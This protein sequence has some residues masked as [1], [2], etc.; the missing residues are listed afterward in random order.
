MSTFIELL[1]NGWQWLGD[2]SSQIQ[3]ASGAVFGLA[4]VVIA[5]AAYLISVKEN[6]GWEPIAVLL[7][8]SLG[9]EGDGQTFMTA[10]F[11]V[12]NR[13]RYPIVVYDVVLTYR[14]A[15]FEKIQD[16]DDPTSE[17]W[18]VRS[19][20]SLGRV[21][22]ELI[23]PGKSKVFNMH[24]IVHGCTMM[25][26][27]AIAISYFD[28]IAAK[29]KTVNGGGGRLSKLRYDYGVWRGSL[30]WL[31]PELRRERRYRR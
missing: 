20:R 18:S 25:E 16:G 19:D 4:A 2:N 27:P 12:W 14:L 3:A 13:R 6:Y 29:V 22:Q 9:V 5:W 11:Q 26:D 31:W 21:S 15:R 30:I 23:D 1:G 8:Y 24:V 28:P 17:D 10:D 7:R